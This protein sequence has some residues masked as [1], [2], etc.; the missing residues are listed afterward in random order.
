MP[1]KSEHRRIYIAGPMRGLPDSN[2]PAFELAATALRQQGWEV[3]SPVEI[4]REYGTEDEIAADPA[5]LNRV[6][7]AELDV[8]PDVDAIYLLRGWQ[9][10][11]GARS[12]LAVAL[13]Y[14]LEIFFQS[15]DPVNG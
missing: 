13:K 10:S 14:D 4:G 5:L 6:M 1:Q 7:M 12:E 11:A 9:R 3:F 15:E 2:I 8:V